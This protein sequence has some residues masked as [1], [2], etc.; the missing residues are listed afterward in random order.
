MVTTSAPKP[1]PPAASLSYEKTSCE[2][3]ARKRRVAAIISPLRLAA[4]FGPLAARRGPTVPR[5][6]CG[7][8]VAHWDR[9]H[10]PPARRIALRAP[11]FTAATLTLP[12]R[13]NYSSR[14]TAE[15]PH[16]MWTAR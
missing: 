10:T 1:T 4:K 6:A 7:T 8:T 14:P 15:P 2:D 11:P 5:T 12:H 3:G 16:W 9:A 13:C